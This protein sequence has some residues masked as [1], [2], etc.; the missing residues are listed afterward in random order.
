M[1]I[2]LL[3]S[4]LCSCSSTMLTSP[5]RAKHE[6]FYRLRRD[7]PGVIYATRCDDIATKKRKCVD[8]D[9]DILDKEGWNEFHDADFVLIPFKYITD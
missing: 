5:V 4:L 3:L 1:R 6:R 2:L 7:L 8:T 9:Y